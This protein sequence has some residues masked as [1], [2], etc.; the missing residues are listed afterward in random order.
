MA[1]QKT[2]DSKHPGPMNRTGLYAYASKYT[3]EAIDVLVEM[4]RT[5]KNESLKLG[6][7]KA[8]LDKNLPDLKATEITGEDHGPLLIKII[9]EQ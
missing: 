6:A 1:T 3:K 4:M 7:A 9:S 5:T 8:L 2:S